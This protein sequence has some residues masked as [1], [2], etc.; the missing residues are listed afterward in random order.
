[1]TDRMAVALIVLLAASPAPA[2]GQSADAAAERARL[3]NE[4]I[5]A[6]AAWRAKEESPAQVQA[7]DPAA[8]A[9]TAPAT[10][11][12]QPTR[13]QAEAGPAPARKAAVD[14]DQTERVLEQLRELG[15]LRDAGYVTD[16]E[17]QRIKQRILDSHF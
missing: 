4:R 14:D 8:A 16:A 13:T 17:F 11:Q 9:A 3:G 12:A 5:Q 7:A 6:E 15:E 2:L 1:M 10:A